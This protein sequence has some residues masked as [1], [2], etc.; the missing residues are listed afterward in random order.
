MAA[1]NAMQPVMNT[2]NRQQ[3]SDLHMQ[4]ALQK[5]QNG[6]ATPEEIDFLADEVKNGNQSILT[7][8]P[9]PVRLAVMEKLETGGTSGS[10]AANSAVTY[11]GSMSEA[12][13]AGRQTGGIDVAGEGFSG[14]APK[15]LA[16]S[17]QV[18][19]SSWKFLAQ[20]GNWFKD[21]QNDP[22]LVKFAN[23]NLGLVREYARA[24]GGTVAA[25][26][27]AQKALGTAKDQTAYKAAVES[28][29]EEISAAQK[30]G[31]RAIKSAGGGASIPD[32]A[33][34]S[35]DG[36]KLDTPPPPDG[37]VVQ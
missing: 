32:P 36:I 23:F 3:L 26:E 1:L 22:A 9:A 19:R 33:G 12:S 17:A 29:Q 8:M 6:Q 4:L 11:H 18:P 20:V 27:K 28:L 31:K 34:G 25:Q 30:G 7:R 5:L 2:T 14:I 15:A 35:D 37:F 16:A 13:A 24:M 10:D 21:Q